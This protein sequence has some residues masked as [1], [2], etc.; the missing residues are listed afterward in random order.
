MSSSESWREGN[1]G[2]SVDEQVDHEP[3]RC[4]PLVWGRLLF[5]VVGLPLFWCWAVPQVPLPT[6]QAAVLVVGGTL[7]YLA[8]AYLFFSQF[9][10]DQFGDAHGYNDH[11]YQMGRG[12][13][14]LRMSAQ[15]F[16]G[17]GRFIA[18]SLLDARELFGSE[19]EA[20]DQSSEK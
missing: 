7:I 2:R 11:P 13:V 15:F 1:R 20:P 12:L 10:I 5:V 16:L 18:E 14:R 4:R 6:W 17:P 19:Q 3:C 9:D 8:M